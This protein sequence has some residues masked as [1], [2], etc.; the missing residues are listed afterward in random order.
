MRFQLVRHKEKFMY[1]ILFMIFLT[2]C[3]YA[4]VVKKD[5]HT[6][7]ETRVVIDDTNDI[8]AQDKIKRLT[9]ENI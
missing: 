4:Q 9:K 8:Q 5:D 6:I 7:T 2:S 1:L 3:A